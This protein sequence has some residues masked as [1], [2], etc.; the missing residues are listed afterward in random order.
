MSHT[1]GPRCNHHTSRLSRRSILGGGAGLFALAQSQSAHAHGSNE[2]SVVLGEHG[3]G[4]RRCNQPLLVKNATILS[5]DPVIGDLAKGD[6]LI[7]HGKIEAIAPTLHVAGAKKL[8]ATGKIVT[9]GFVDTHRH[10]WQGL[11]RNSGPNESLFDYLGRVLFGLGPLLTPDD[12][13][14]GNLLS[15][16]SALN[17]GVTTILDWSHIATSSDHTD[18]AVDG[19][20]SSGIR[21]VYAYGANIGVQPPWY[22]SPDPFTAEPFPADLFRLKSTRFSSDDQLLTLALAAGGPDFASVDVAAIEWQLARQADVRITVHAGLGDPQNLVNLNQALISS[23]ELG[24][25]NDTTYVHASHLSNESW[26]LIHDTGGTISMSVPVELQ[27]GHGTPVIQ[28]A[29]DF[30]LKPSLSVDVETNTPTDMFHQMRSCFALHRG[31]VN[32][33]LATGTP[34]V[35]RQALEFATI[36]GALAN[37]LGSRTGSLT[38]GKRA[39]F[40]MLN[41]RAINVAPINDPVAAVVLGMDTSNVEAVFVDGKARKWKGELVGVNLERLIDEATDAQRAL[42]ERAAAYSGG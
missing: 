16:L 3:P 19:L 20:E 12:V 7:R 24:L 15:S 23:G 42:Y 14:L 11:L 39:D 34:L 2:D 8:D 1:C 35:A 29:L 32:A 31:L 5:M 22:T 18:A 17:S 10:L 21:G 33:G 26:Q 30:G 4:T 28:T 27:M 40:L 41:A 25:A 9:P 37:G 36:N 38:V 6:M 13:Y